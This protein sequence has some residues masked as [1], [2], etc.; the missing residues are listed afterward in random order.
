MTA[1]ELFE[2]F[3][4]YRVLVV[5][6]VMLDRYI[7]GE[8]NRISPE[9]PVPVVAVQRTENRLGGA[10]N[11]ALNLH[12]L[13]IQPLLCGAVGTDSEGADFRAVLQ[14]HGMAPDLLLETPERPTTVK[15]RVL[16]MGQQML[17]IDRENAVPLPPERLTRL[18]E[19]LS[20]LVG[21]GSVHAVIFEDYNKGLL[22]PGFVEPIIR[23][24]KA[25]CV[26]VFVDPKTEHTDAFRGCTVFKP[27]QKELESLL[28]RP[29]KPAD[30]SAMRTALKEVRDRLQADY[31]LATLGPDGLALVGKDIGYMHVPAERRQVVDVSGAGDTVIAAFTAALIAG[32]PATKAAAFANRAAALVLDRV[33]VV[34]VSGRALREV[35]PALLD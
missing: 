22:Q 11:V 6:D 30:E 2:R 1:P 8:T 15:S 32:L 12:A 20:K 9:A 29:V 34:P 33:G 17:R 5:G 25:A 24:A 23:A 26:P 4:Q 16:A 27:N 10:A 35:T 31:V 19:R 3:R 18:A 21:N 7:F 28:N 14:R 13:G